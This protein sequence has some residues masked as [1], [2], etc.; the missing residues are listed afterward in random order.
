[1]SHT[2]KNFV[3]FNNGERKSILARY[4]IPRYV[5]DN[6]RLFVPEEI[7]VSAGIRDLEIWARLHQ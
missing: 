4:K 3:E 1:M 5:W 2:T 6:C 7:Y